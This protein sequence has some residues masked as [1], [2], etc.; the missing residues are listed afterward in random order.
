MIPSAD[1]KRWLAEPLFF[2]NSQRRLGIM[3]I[4]VHSMTYCNPLDQKNLP[5]R[6]PSRK[7]WEMW[8]S[9]PLVSG[10]IYGIAAVFVATPS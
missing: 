1:L 6:F 2:Y 9:F 3:Y 4:F 7:G 5:W 10:G 8:G